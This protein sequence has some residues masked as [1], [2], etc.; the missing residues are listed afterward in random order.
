MEAT[1]PVFK[2][3]YRRVK[4]GEECVRVLESTGA[5]NYKET[6]NAE[7][8]ELGES[9]LWRAGAAVRKLRPIK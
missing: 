6:L 5:A 3:L 2:E 7:L 4:T 8:K 1:L 9:E